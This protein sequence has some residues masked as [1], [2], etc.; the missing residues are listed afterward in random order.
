MSL[1][2]ARELISAARRVSVLTGAGISTASGIPDF[3]GPAGRWTLDP[4]AEKI[5]TLSY[6]LNDPAVRA[7]AWQARAAA[8]FWAAKPNAGHR[9]LVQL[10]TEGKLTGIITQNTDG[11]QQEAGS[12]PELVHEVHGNART[13]RCED[14][15][16]EGPMMEMV[17]RVWA[18]ET[19]PRCPQCGGIVRAT[20]I[21]FEEALVPE[22][23]DAAAD[24]VAESDLLLAV[25]SSLTVQP[26]AGFVPW[27]VQHGINLVLV[28]AEPTPYD[29][30]A[31]AVVRD[32]I[33]SALPQL[34]APAA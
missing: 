3:R 29:R 7:K 20:V 9:A 18:G 33:V 11:L 13:W 5:S 22:V 26:V 12:N 24:A 17:E 8:E 21:L 31:A 10:E 2:S 30:L 23:L 32:P 6:Y 34:C 4:D 14:C 1:D 15:R 28:N 19:D 25:G 16:R 27:A